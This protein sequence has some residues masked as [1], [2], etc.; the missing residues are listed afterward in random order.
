MRRLKCSTVL[1]VVI[2]LLAAEYCW[3]TTLNFHQ[4]RAR[5][6]HDACSKIN[7]RV[8]EKLDKKC[9]SYDG[10]D[11]C[12]DTVSSSV[13]ECTTVE[14]ENCSRQM[15]E[16]QKKGS[17][18]ECIDPASPVGAE[19]YLHEK[20]NCKKEGKECQKKSG[21]VHCIARSK[22][23]TC[24]KRS[25]DVCKKLG[26]NCV[27]YDGTDVCVDETPTWC[28]REKQDECREFLKV[29]DDSS[30]VPQCML[31]TKRKSRTEQNGM[32]NNERCLQ[33]VCRKFSRDMK[34]SGWRKQNNDFERH[35]G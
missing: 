9:V 30:G 2:L 20:E 14:A 15:K 25:L 10:T 4:L 13:E 11:A 22:S 16:C 6:K 32:R 35:L 19:C 3:C 26:K 21:Q 17:Q 33:S 24:S 12:V 29:C 28:T 1:C 7:Q 34:E 5:R 31:N 27:S 18:A 23:Q 8:C